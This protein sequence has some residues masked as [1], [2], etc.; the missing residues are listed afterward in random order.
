MI[1]KFHESRDNSPW[2]ADFSEAMGR[3]GQAGD[4]MVRAAEVSGNEDIEKLVHEISRLSAKCYR[5][6][7]RLTKQMTKRTLALEVVDDP[8]IDI[9]GHS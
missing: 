3:L 2:Q 4:A 1:M 7:K 9:G 6:S 5:L 8:P